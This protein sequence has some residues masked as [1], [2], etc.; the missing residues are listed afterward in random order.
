MDRKYLGRKQG[1]SAP[2]PGSIQNIDIKYTEY[3]QKVYRIQTESI[4]NIDRKHIQNIDRKD[5]K[6]KLEDA[7]LKNNFEDA[8]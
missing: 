4:Q 7:Y 5:N 1:G 6:L 3:R 2:P 8:Y